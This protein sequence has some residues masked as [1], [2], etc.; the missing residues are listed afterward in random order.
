MG[1]SL[2]QSE[3][4]WRG[5]G[6]V[7]LVPSESEGGTR[8]SHWRSQRWG[9]SWQDPADAISGV[10]G[11]ARAGKHLQMLPAVLA[12]GAAATGVE[13]ASICKYCQQHQQWGWPCQ[14]GTCHPPPQPPLHALPMDGAPRTPRGGAGCGVCCCVGFP[15]LLMVTKQTAAQL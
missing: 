13:L 9:W 12:A 3:S 2:G 6:Y 5:R 11:W 1:S 15:C 7:R 14:G 10:H 4:R 8:R